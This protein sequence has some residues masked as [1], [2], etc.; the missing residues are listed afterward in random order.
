MLKNNSEKFIY[1]DVTRDRKALLP[2]LLNRTYFNDKYQL[3]IRETETKHR[4]ELYVS[5]LDDK[6]NYIK[7]SSR[8]TA[9]KVVSIA[10]EFGIELKLT[11]YKHKNVK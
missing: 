9:S 10:S 8:T 2:A 7:T 3:F 4:Y 11:S 1:S 6:Y 5:R